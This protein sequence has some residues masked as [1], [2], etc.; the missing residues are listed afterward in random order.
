MLNIPLIGEKTSVENNLTL[1]RN[2]GGGAWPQ[3]MLECWKATFIY[4]QI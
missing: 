3:F 1:F 4:I 2:K